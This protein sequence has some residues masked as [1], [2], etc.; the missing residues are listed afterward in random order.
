MR[1]WIRHPP[2]VTY[3]VEG[4]AQIPLAA[5]L[6][7][8]EG[9]DV[10]KAH[11]KGRRRTGLSIC[12]SAST[13][14]QWQRNL[15][16]FVTSLRASKMRKQM[17]RTNCVMSQFLRMKGMKWGF[18]SNSFQSSTSSSCTNVFGS[19]DPSAATRTSANSCAPPDG[20]GSAARPPGCTCSGP[21]ARCSAAAPARPRR[22]SAR[23]S[24]PRRDALVI[25]AQ[26]RYPPGRRR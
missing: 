13:L 26:P 14:P 18:S 22:P 5:Y 3:L 11:L 25:R 19:A 4:D 7:Q 2:H 15:P 1:A 24:P 23:G 16:T 12:P 6:Q 10:D 20:T 8:D 9:A 17:G 21:R